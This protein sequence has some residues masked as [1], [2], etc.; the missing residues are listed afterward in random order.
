[1]LKLPKK[2]TQHICCLLYTSLD[3]SDA[4]KVT[5][6][7]GIIE[8][9]EY[10]YDGLKRLTNE[11]VKKGNTT[12]TYAYEYDDYGNRSKMTATGTEDYV[13]EYNYNNAQGSYTALLQKGFPAG[14]IAPGATPNSP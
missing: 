5:E 1:M 13:T 12:D 2:Y 9:T 6:E 10:E 14:L 7:N 3:G 8:T 4:C 11:E